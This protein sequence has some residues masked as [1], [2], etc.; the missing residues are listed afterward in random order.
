MS[1]GQ[2]LAFGAV[3]AL[4]FVVPA[5]ASFA[6][7][8]VGSAP[9]AGGEVGVPPDPASGEGGDYVGLLPEPGEGGDYVGL[10]PGSGDGGEYVGLPPGLVAGGNLGVEG[11]GVAAPLRPRVSDLDGGA[12]GDD[13]GRPV[14]RIGPDEEGRPAPGSPVST[15]DVVVLG[16]LAT[17]GLA[18]VAARRVRMPR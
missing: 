3:L 8:Y 9:G 18:V 15:S 7:D 1:A 16:A 13:R 14:L 2:L 6:Q 12:L 11:T 10:P 5:S 17:A 4:A